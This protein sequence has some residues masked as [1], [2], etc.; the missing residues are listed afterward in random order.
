MRNNNSLELAEELSYLYI[1]NKPDTQHTQK[2][3]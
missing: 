1:L 2:N 3:G